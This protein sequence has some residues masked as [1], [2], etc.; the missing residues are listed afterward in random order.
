VGSR[1]CLKEVRLVFRSLL[2]VAC[3]LIQTIFPVHFTEFVLHEVRLYL[4]VPGVCNLEVDSSL[5]PV[6]ESVV[7]FEE[8]VSEVDVIWI[9][10]VEE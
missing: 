2:T 3:S 5:H 10:D 4:E 7:V 9:G 6:V 1:S 8:P